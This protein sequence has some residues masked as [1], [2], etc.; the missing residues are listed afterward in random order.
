MHS[1]SRGR[2]GW[3][4]A[5]FARPSEGVN[6]T[7]VRIPFL[8]SIFSAKLI[9]HVVCAGFN[10]DHVFACEYE[11]APLALPAAVL[12]SLS[13]SSTIPDQLHQPHKMHRAPTLI[14]WRPI[15]VLVRHN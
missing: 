7:H 14:P 4:L 6:T 15:F 8:T 5:A 3:M 13:S 10:I 12:S 2:A 9:V 1:R 11:L